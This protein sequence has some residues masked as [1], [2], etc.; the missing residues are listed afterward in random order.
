MSTLTPPDLVLKIIES[1]NH[2]EVKLAALSI[3]HC[4]IHDDVE[5]EDEENPEVASDP[6]SGLPPQIADAI[7]K[8]SSETGV[9]LSNIRVQEIK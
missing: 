6:L 1:D 5:L 7:R 2:P 8:V 3:V 9:P 4:L